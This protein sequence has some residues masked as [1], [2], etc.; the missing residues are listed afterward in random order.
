MKDMVCPLL[1]Q[2]IC[3]LRELRTRIYENLGIPLSRESHSRDRGIYIGKGERYTSSSFNASHL[4]GFRM[5]RI[6]KEAQHTLSHHLMNGISIK[7]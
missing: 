6:R 7:F 4:K 2:A 5:P 1:T 3:L